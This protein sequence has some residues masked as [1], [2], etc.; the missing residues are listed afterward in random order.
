MIG[1][2][3]TVVG[4]AVV[5]WILRGKADGKHPSRSTNIDEEDYE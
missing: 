2:I 1:F 3:I 4:G 5:G